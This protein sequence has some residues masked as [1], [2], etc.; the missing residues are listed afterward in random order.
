M[1]DQSAGRCDRRSAA[2]SNPSVVVSA[3]ECAASASIAADPVSAPATAFI[4]AINALTTRAT[5][6]VNVLSPCRSPTCREGE[7]A[8]PA[9]LSRVGWRSPVAAATDRRHPVHHDESGYHHRQ[10]DGPRNIRCTGQR[11]D[12]YGSQGQRQQRTGN[13]LRPMQV[14]VIVKVC[15]GVPE[16]LGTA[17]GGQQRYI[18]RRRFHGSVSLRRPSSGNNR[19]PRTSRSKP[20]EPPIRRYWR[21]RGGEVPRRSSRPAAQA[22]RLPPRCR[23]RRRWSRNRSRR[24][25]PPA[26][27]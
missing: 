4:T 25:C 6:T 13:G 1:K 14:T 12:Q 24:W 9:R 22:R 5:M 18:V 20:D 27:G 10:Q 8:A 26:P 19:F 2:S 17:T 11:G 16:S 23:A 7:P 3:T 21:L 15:L